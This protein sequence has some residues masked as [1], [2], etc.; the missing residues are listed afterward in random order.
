MYPN[1]P[2]LPDGVPADPAARPPVLSGGDILARL[3][4]ALA[5]TEPGR[6]LPDPRMGALSPEDRARVLRLFPPQPSPAAVLV[7]IVD[8]PGAPCVLFTERAPMLKHHAGQISFPGGR[9]EPADGGPVA[10]AL[11]ETEEEIGLARTAVEVLGFLPDHL[12]I[13]GYRVTP[14]VG[15]VRP[16]EVLRPD[17]REVASVFEVPL[18]FLL[19]PANHVP[20]RRLIGGVVEV[21]LQDIPWQDRRIWG[22]TAAMVLMLG[23]VLRDG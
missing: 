10:A 11:R 17:P 23:E 2:T 20:N 13:S 21:T 6:L 9:I 16:G 14:V 22:A 5:G 4:A 18:A 3:R 19:D 7:P 15:L 12:V 1:D 8:H